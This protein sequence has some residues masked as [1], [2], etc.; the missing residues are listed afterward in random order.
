MA[1]NLGKILACILWFLGCVGVYSF[2]KI[3]IDK[4]NITNERIINAVLLISIFL[5]FIVVLIFIAK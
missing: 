1:D 2:L 3:T 4:K 5:I